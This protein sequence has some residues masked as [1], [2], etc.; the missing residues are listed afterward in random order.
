MPPRDGRFRVTQARTANT[1][2]IG[3][4]QHKRPTSTSPLNI[5]CSDT[6]LDTSKGIRAGTNLSKERAPNRIPAALLQHR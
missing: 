3:A 6:L 2:Q 5:D 1:F 4:P